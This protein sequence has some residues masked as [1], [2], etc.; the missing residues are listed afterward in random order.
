MKHRQVLIIV[1]RLMFVL[2]FFDSYAQ[3]SI[4]IIPKPKEIIIG[5]GYFPLHDA[6][7]VLPA[8]VDQKRIA[9]FFADE[10][11]QQTGIDLLKKKSINIISFG[12]SKS[13]QQQEGYEISITP[14]KI[15][16]SAKNSIGLLWAVQ[17]IRQFMPLEKKDKV[18]IPCLEIK[19]FPLY[20]WRS[21]MLDV[22]RHFFSV[23]FIKKHIDM[24]SYYKFNTFHWHLTDDQGWRIE[25]K[26]Y[27]ELTS[28]GA[29]RNE[30]NGE[31]YG[32]FYTQEEIKEVV[33]YAQERNI[34]IIPEIEMPG[35]CLAALASY[36]ELSCRKSGFEVATYWGVI[37]DVYCAGN[38]KTYKFIEDVLDEVL[39]LFPSKYIHIG[40]DEVPKYRWQQCSVCQQKIKDEHLQNE[41]ELQSYFVKRIQKYLQS[42][43]RTLIGWD[44]ILEGG[45][46][47]DAI[48]EV[49]RGPE[50]ANEAIANKNK[51]IQTLYFDSPMSSLNLSKTFNYDPAVA[52]H[53]DN[54]LGAECPLWTEGITEYNADYMLYPRLQAF[55]E[56]LWSGKTDFDDFKNRLKYHYA[57]MDKKDILYGDENK[58][59]LNVSLK[60]IP[61]EKYWRLFEKHGI[62]DMVICYNDGGDSPDNKP[63]AFSDSISLINPSSF[64]VAA[65]RHGKHASMP[66]IFQV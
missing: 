21:N 14:T 63:T 26:K 6:R 46:T 13:I 39:T 45:I 49:W 15:C 40:G 55:S 29:W 60:Y 7:L 25:I 42:K 11:L 58:I 24:L 17:S 22:S 2:A 36:A 9:L 52:N 64:S 48:I 33:K 51:I 37:N 4:S 28:V 57:L 35:H 5:K 38:E 59:F 1:L 44:E 43:N 18:L 10:V 19:D 31:K 34:T 30:V 47:D 50:K 62:N 53:N 41:H 65:F 23:E 27:P 16:I 56:V 54:V 66:V 32:G 12:Y 61:E 8:D 3:P 20:P